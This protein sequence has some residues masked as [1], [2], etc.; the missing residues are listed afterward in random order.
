MNSSNI[1]HVDTSARKLSFLG[2]EYDC[3][4]GKT[5][6]TPEADKCEGDNKTP[7]GSYPLRTGFYRADKN[8]KPATQLDMTVITKQMGWCDEA[9]HADYNRFVTLPFD[10]SHELMWREQ[11]DC[12]DIVVVLGHNDSPP[13]SGMGSAIFMHV[14]KENYTGTEGCVAL[15]KDDLVTLLRNCDL[16]TKIVIF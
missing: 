16:D 12:Y 14:A 9:G 15:A 3:A 2:A 6:A 7:L 8:D 5:G 1:I 10:A 4:I 13:I 11:D